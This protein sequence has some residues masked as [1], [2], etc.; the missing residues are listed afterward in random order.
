MLPIGT[1]LT[2]GPHSLFPLD[3]TSVRMDVALLEIHSNNVEP[4]NISCSF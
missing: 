2:Y 1:I 4:S 3:R